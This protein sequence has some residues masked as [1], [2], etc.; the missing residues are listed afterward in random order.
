MTFAFFGVNPS[1]TDATLDDATARKCIG[2]TKP[3][4]GRRLIVGNVFAVRSTD[5][6]E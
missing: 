3:N 5:V 1:T 2:F 6:H 4:G